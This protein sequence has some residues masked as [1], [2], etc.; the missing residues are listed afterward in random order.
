MLTYAELS[1]ILVR[2]MDPFLQGKK[3]YS[4]DLTTEAVPT[5]QQETSVVRNSGPH[6]FV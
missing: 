4:H 5:L 1:E 2:A 6:S 3:L